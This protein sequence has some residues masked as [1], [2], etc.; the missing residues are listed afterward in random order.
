MENLP[1]NYSRIF[2]FQSFERTRRRILSEAAAEEEG[3]MVK[4]IYKGPQKPPSITRV[5]TTSCVSGGLVCHSP[6]HRRTLVCDGQRASRE[7][8]DSSVSAAS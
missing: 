2:Q 6:C 4:K 3:A 8:F 1:Q 7:T 5:I